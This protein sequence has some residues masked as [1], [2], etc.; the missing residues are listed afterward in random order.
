LYFTDVYWP[1]FGKAE[2]IKAIEEYKSR[3]RRFGK[4]GEQ[5]EGAAQRA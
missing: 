1:D 4:T 5:I 2:L 3:Q